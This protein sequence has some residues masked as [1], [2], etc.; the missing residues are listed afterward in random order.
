MEAKWE[1][2]EGR[3]G[4]V[5]VGLMVGK[6]SGGAGGARGTTEPC[7]ERIE[8][9]FSKALLATSRLNTFRRVLVTLLR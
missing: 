3:Q 9:R 1:R 7:C 4:R 8:H 2:A 6:K 5:R